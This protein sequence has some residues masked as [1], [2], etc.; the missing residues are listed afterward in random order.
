MTVFDEFSDGGYYPHADCAPAC[1]LSALAD[2]GQR[3]GTREVER[4][5]GSTPN[6]T[7]LPGISN[8]LTHFGLANA[9]HQGNPAAAWIM[10]PAGG[11]IIDPSGFPAYLA[12]SWGWVVTITSAE[13]WETHS[14]LPEE[15]D[16]TVLAVRSAGSVDPHGP[17]AVYLVK[18]VVY[19]PKRWVTTV[20][21]LGVYEALLGAPKTI[22]AYVL[23]R[24]EEG[25]KIDQVASPPEP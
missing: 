20:G 19:G 7:S 24:M 12:A 25:P 11:R 22:N 15:D 4:E 18:D 21:A 10:N 2:R 1:A 17:G 6:G 3:P 5:A 8:A 23:D 13:P 14:P 16:V 9:W